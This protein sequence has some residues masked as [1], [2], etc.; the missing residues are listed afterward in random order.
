MTL[1]TQEIQELS[2]DELE[3]QIERHNRLYWQKQAPEIPDTLY[4]QLVEQLRARSPESD[5]LSSLGDVPSPDRKV[6]HDRPM[7]SLE[8]C[9]SREEIEK[10]FDRFEGHALASPKIDGLALSLRYDEHGALSLGVTRGD[11]LQGDTITENVKQVANIPTSIDAADIEVRGEAYLPLSRFREAYADQFANPRNLAAGALKQKDPENTAKYGIRFFAYEL[12]GAGD[13]TTEKQRF[14]K[15]KELGF[16]HVPLRDATKEN[17][18]EV[19]EGYSSTRAELDYETDGVVFRV[20]DTT[21]HEAMGR[22]AHHPRYAIAYKYQGESGI[23]TLE[24]IEWSLSRTGKINPVAL[25]SPI[26]LSGVTVGR[27][28]LHNLGIMEKLAGDDDVLKLG[29]KVLVTRRGGVIPHIEAVT[30]PG[31]TPVEI[32]MQ[33]PSCGADTRREEDFLVAD[34]APDCLISAIKR[35]EHFASVTDM[36]GVGPKLLAQLFDADLVQEP[37]DLYLLEPESI[38][39]LDRMGTKSAENA[40]QAVRARKKLKL[41]TFLT[42]LGIQDLGRHVSRTV[43]AHYRSLEKIREASPEEL[44]EIDGI[45]EVIAEHV[46]LGLKEHAASIDRMLDHVTLEIPDAEELPDEEDPLFSK[47]FVFTGAMENLVRKDAQARVRE[48]GGETPS[49]VSSKLSYLVLGNGDMDRFKDG[50]RSSKLKKAEQYMADGAD[51]KIISESE[52]LAMVD[53]GR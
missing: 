31:E 13:I 32:P 2:V 8:K 6:E 48:L 43:A 20:N 25:I 34:H 50:W 24:D 29:S 5:V 19:F 10:W 21:Q 16:E 45:G 49:G 51:L 42:S 41:S 3:E 15:L 18:Q 9:Y 38:A 12:L 17:A 39:G 14:A 4:D 37:A 52:F 26:S 40:V 27:V 53:A 36:Q 1:S 46:V 23:S 44:T 28:S 7:L 33:C 11:G 22:T 47:S 30:E 35:L